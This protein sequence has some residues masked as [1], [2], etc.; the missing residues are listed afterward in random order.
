MSGTR[1]KFFQDA[2]IFGAG[3]F[4]LS[5]PLRAEQATGAREARSH[6]RNAASPNSPAVAS[7]PTL[8][9]DI[10]NLPFR[11]DGEVKEFHLIA[12]PVKQEIVPGR[13]VDLWGYNGSAPGPTIQVN[14]GDRVRIIVDNQHRE[15][16]KTRSHPVADSSTSSRSTRKE[17]TSTTPT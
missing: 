3:L 6:P 2:A 13:T 4:G 14:Q 7:P 9:P 8:T 10:P 1:R 15:Q 16:A 12:E 17:R 5:S 11:M